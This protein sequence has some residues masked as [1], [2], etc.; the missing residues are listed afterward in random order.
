MYTMFHLG[1][2]VFR[3]SLRNSENIRIF[4]VQPGDL[5]VLASTGLWKTLTS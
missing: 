4:E 2:V 5:L 1:F 3:S